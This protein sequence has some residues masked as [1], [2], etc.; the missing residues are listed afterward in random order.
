MNRIIIL[1]MC[2]ILLFYLCVYNSNKMPQAP[3]G[4]ADSNYSQESTSETIESEINFFEQLPQSFV[5]SSGV[6]G[7]STDLDLN[8]DGTFTG[9]YHDSDMGDLDDEYP[10]GTVYICEFSGKFS[11]P[12]KIDEHTYSMKLEYLNTEGTIDDEYYENGIRYIYSGPYGLE[13]AD[14]FL[15]YLPGSQISDLPEEFVSWLYAFVDVQTE[16][17]LP[18]YGIYNVGGKT[19]FVACDPDPSY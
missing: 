8:S 2:C 11:D 19:G 16:K 15:L 18:Y 14:E 17:T 1:L 3:N 10:N 4:E 12:V 5:F 7:W 9:I 13:N 6:G